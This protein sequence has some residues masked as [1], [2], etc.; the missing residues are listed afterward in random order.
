MTQTA[1]DVA[2]TA[3]PEEE[4][5]LAGAPRARLVEF[6]TARWCA[7]HSLR[8]LGAQAGAILPG[9]HGEPQWPPGFVGSLTHC[10]GLRA[11]AVASSK[12]VVALGI[13]A[14]EARALPPGVEGFIADESERK[15]LRHLEQE[16]LTVSWGMVLFCCKEAIFKLWHPATGAWLSFRDVRVTLRH[17]QRFDVR[18][19]STVP[20]VLNGDRTLHLEG[21]WFQ[22]PTHVGAL[23]AVAAAARSMAS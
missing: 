10:T 6:R 7:R 2:E 17:D 22:T 1:E 5:H 21:Q 14:E 4:T 18:L 19:L 13:D 12:D 11:A 9:K 8:L 16:S 23:L 15:H 3:H 20:L